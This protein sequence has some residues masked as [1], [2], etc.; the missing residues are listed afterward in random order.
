MAAFALKDQDNNDRTR[1]DLLGKV[2]IA[3]FQFTRC[4]GPCPTISKT[5]ERLQ[6]DLASRPDVR[7]VTFTVDPDNDGPSELKEY[8]GRFHAN[9]DRWLFL[10]GKDREGL[11]RFFREQFHI[12]AALRE[13]NVPVGQKVDHQTRLVLIDRKGYIRGYYDGLPDLSTGPGESPLPD[14]EKTFEQD[15]KRLERRVD[16][17]LLPETPSYLPS[18]FP[19]FNAFLNGVCVVL[20]LL[21]YSAIRLRLYRVHGALMLTAIAVSA[22]FLASYLYFHI[23]IKGGQPTRFADQAIGAPAWVGWLYAGILLT[24]T[25][26]AVVATPL[27]LYTAYQGLAGK[28]RRHVWIGRITLPVWL[29][30]SVTGVV[31][32]W[33]LY[34]MYP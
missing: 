20:L 6:K 7:L 26:L 28:L 2:W 14:P 17:L 5:M 10:W 30:V 19:F 4:T 8:A 24:H 18:D 34:R 33:M 3:S 21:G 29:Y 1:D 27:A 31:V 16:K 11:Y 23:V 22:L 15:L 9:P 32:Y 12:H 13:G 25:L